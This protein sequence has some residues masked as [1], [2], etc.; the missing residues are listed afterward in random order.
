MI[1]V[2]RSANPMELGFIADYNNIDAVIWVGGG[3]VSWSALASVLVGEVNP[4]GRTVDTW[5]LSLETEPAFNASSSSYYANI[6]DLH[7]LVL[8]D[9]G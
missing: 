8:Q 7:L 5:P 1:L 3:N 6:S 9:S 2:I 4:S